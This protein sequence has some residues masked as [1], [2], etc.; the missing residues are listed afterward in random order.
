LAGFFG[1]GNYQN[2]G[3]GIAKN[4]SSKG[5][6]G[7]FFE[8]L[9]TRIWKLFS[10][11]FLYVIFCIPIITI[12]PATAGIT[13]VLKNYS[14]DKNAYVWSDFISTFKKNFLKTFILGLFDLIAY[15][16][17]AT[18]CYIYPKMSEAS[19]NNLFYVLFVLTLSVAV[20]FTIMNFYMY[21]MIVSTDLSMKNI[22]KNSLVLTFLAPKQNLLSLFLMVIISA[23]FLLLPLW[24]LQFL[25]L[26]LF[27]PATFIVFIICYNCYPVIQKY[28]INPYYE[29]TGKVNP[30]S[31]EAY[32]ESLFE[33]MGGK[34]T[35]IELKK[36]K[37]GRTIS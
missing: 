22:I 8:I 14:I 16:G 17:V 12:G 7:L 4:R 30:E 37:K 20:T 29:K 11:N 33:D 25:F 13:K 36:S 24:N 2:S 9:S 19:G 21:L 34:E 6:L 18:G 32:E 35:P 26:M 28:V 10:L 23:I 31:P 27:V 1:L 3:V 5:R 15:A